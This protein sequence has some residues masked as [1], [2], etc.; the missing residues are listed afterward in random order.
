MRALR[1]PRDNRA[2]AAARALYAARDEKRWFVDFLRGTYIRERASTA[3]I[4]RR[5]IGIYHTT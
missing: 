5:I 1:P 4:V 2:A 3:D